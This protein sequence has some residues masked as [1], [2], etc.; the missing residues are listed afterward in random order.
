MGEIDYVKR[1]FAVKTERTFGKIKDD[2]WQFLK[3]N[4]LWLKRAPGPPGTT[5]LTA[6]G[7]LSNVPRNASLV[8]V[9]RDIYNIIFQAST[10]AEKE[11]AQDYLQTMDE[12]G[13]DNTNTLHIHIQ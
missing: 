12:L 9:N 11:G 7:V 8:S 6:L 2:C 1:Y 10:A 5:N 13:L 4:S 3:Q